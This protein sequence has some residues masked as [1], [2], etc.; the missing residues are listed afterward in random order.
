MDVSPA[1]Q[2]S[3]NVS[4]DRDVYLVLEILGQKLFSA[5]VTAQAAFH[6]LSLG[7]RYIGFHCMYVSL[8]DKR[9]E[10]DKRARTYSVLLNSRARTKDNLQPRTPLILRR[11]CDSY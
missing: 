6:K 9:D 2:R 7:V 4:V 10:R 5:G 3:S 11:V 8:L 1:Q